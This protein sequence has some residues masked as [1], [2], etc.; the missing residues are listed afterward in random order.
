M[1]NTL[2]GWDDGRIY[3]YNEEEKEF[4]INDYQEFFGQLVK[5]CAD[6]FEQ[7]EERERKYFSGCYRT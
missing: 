6:Y 3:F 7:K 4:C 1:G 2:Y 5:M